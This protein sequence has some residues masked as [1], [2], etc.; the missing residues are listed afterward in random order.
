MI[1]RKVLA[2]GNVNPFICKLF[3]TFETDGYLFFAM[4][5]CAGGD[6]MFHVQREGKFTESRSR[7]YAAEIIC[8]IRFLH[9]RHIIYRDLKLD[10]ILLDSHGHIRLVDFGMCQCR[11]YREEMLPSNFC[12]T[13]EYISPE[14]IKGVPYNHSV[15]WWSFGVLLYE[16]VV[17]KMPF[18]GNDENELL[19]NVCYEQIHYP[20]FLT[21]DLTDLLKLL[22]EREPTKRMGMASCK[23]GDIY[24]QP[25]FRGINWTA[26]EQL[27]VEPPFIPEVR[28]RR[29]VQ[30]FDSDFTESACELSPVDNE[31]LG[32][33][34]Q[35]QF[36]KFPYT[37]PDI[38][39]F[40]QASAK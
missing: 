24:D 27:K 21:K 14:I 19:W 40:E 17:G 5:Y 33:I 20:M 6:L 32:K 18:R 26:I 28:S 38:F 11:T 30:N 7:F 2:L 3:C 23:A 15:D 35:S 16:M 9:N 4:E 36:Q 10:N 39:I 31:T 8:A 22:L 29:D 1:E 34:D 25:F 12:G 37:N 13:P